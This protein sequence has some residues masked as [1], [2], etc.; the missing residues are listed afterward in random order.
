M[1]NGKPAFRIFLHM[2]D[3]LVNILVE[4]ELFF[5]RYGK[6]GEHVAAR[7]R[8]HKRFLWIDKLWV[9]EIRRSS[10]RLHFVS[11][12]KFPGVIARIFLI[13][14]RRV[15]AFPSESNFMFGHAFK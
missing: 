2:A 12:V 1:R 11:A 15:A 9:S 7:K 14:E 4:H 3:R 10:R 6:K 8:R 13:L 5:G